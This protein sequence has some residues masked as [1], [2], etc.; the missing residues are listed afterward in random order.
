LTSNEALVSPEQGSQIPDYETYDFASVWRGR[1]I[2]DAAERTLVQKW[3]RTGGGSALD[4][5]GGFGRITSVLE[6]LYRNVFMVDYSRRN[7]NAAASR[8][9]R[10]TLVRCELGVLPFEDNTFDFVSLIRVM[11]HIP[12]PS[13]LLAEVA[14]VGRE[15]GIFVMSDPNGVSQRLLKRGGAVGPSGAVRVG[16]QG[17]LS[18]ATR[19]EQYRNPSLVREETRGLGWFDNKLGMKL[20][21]LAPLSSVDVSTS[22]LWP[23]KTNL[24]LKFTIRKAGRR[25]QTKTEP[26]VLCRSGGRIVQARCERCGRQYGRIIDLVESGD[27]GLWRPDGSEEATR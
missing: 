21:R 12:K 13:H 18:Y 5:G 22:R 9:R 17:H 19:L 14:R 4:L 10:T 15:G 20:E 2:A 3:A 7:L 8:L 27:A 25:G 1:G 16:P 6:P 24:F 11:H 26:F 23:V